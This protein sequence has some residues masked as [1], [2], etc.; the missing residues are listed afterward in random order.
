MKS[1]ELCDGTVSFIFEVQTSQYYQGYMSASPPSVSPS[2]PCHGR[3]RYCHHRIR[4]HRHR[5]SN[6]GVVK[7][8]SKELESR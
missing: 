8:K 7:L 3:H 1:S 6:A 2:G 5:G 4:R